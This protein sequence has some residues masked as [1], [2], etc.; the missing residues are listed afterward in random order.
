MTLPSLQP[1]RSW[2]LRRAEL[3][4]LAAGVIGLVACHGCGRP[5]A[6]DSDESAPPFAFRSLD[7]QQRTKD[8]LPAWSLKSPEARYDIRSSVARVLRPEGVIFANGK[9]LYRLASTTGTVINDGEVILMEGSIRLQRL[10]SNP[11]LISADRALWIPGKSLMRFEL[12]PRVR[13]PQNQLSSQSATLLLDRD[14]LQ[15]RGQPQLERWSQP[16]PLSGPAPATAPDIIGTVRAVDWHPG[17]GDL[18]GQGPVWFSRRPPRSAATR[19]P[20]V[21]RAARLEGNTLRQLYTLQGPVT[22]ED[23]AER[24]WF[25]GG[26]LQLDGRNQS[27]KSADPFQAQRGTLWLAGETLRVEAQPTTVSVEGRCRLRQ[28]GGDELESR[29]CRWNWTTQAVEAEG[30][31]LLRRPSN[32]QSTRAQR[33]AGQL[34]PKGQVL[35]ST[36]GG[37]VVTEVQV[38]RRAGR[39]RPPRTPAKPLPI[40][41]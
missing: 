1:S 20:Q 29:L 21:L 3:A 19:A 35:A 39:P 36:P 24:G 16:F 28:S 34:G 11:L 38:P 22:I 40:A 27:L 37:R 14:L 18:Q 31:V 26:A 12:N 13:N 17:T 10:G 2:R 15:L 6:T 30:D 25:R 4:A 5:L 7:L 33:I 41:F 32:G 9:P 23:P 8:G